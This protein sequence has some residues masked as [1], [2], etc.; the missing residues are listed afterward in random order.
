M[1]TDC[2]LHT[3]L[4]AVFITLVLFPTTAQSI[5]FVLLGLYVSATYFSHRVSKPWIFASPKQEIYNIARCLQTALYIL[6]FYVLI[7][8]LYFNLKFFS[9][10][11]RQLLYNADV[12]MFTYHLLIYDTLLVFIIL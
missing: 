5:V 4:A 3:F 9:N 7:F 8:H 6:T 2:M 10:T 11:V 1:T 12:C